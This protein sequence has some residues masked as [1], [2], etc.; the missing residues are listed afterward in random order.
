MPCASRSVLKAAL[1]RSSSSVSAG[2][3]L[4]DDDQFGEELIELVVLA[5]RQS[6]LDRLG[7]RFH[8]PAKLFEFTCLLN[9]QTLVRSC[10]PLL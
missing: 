1:A 4:S 3:L 5:E 10:L 9:H 7:E 6:P 8:R 2:D